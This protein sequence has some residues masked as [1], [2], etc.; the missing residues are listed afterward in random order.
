MTLRPIA[1]P[2]GWNGMERW[3][4]MEH[5]V[6]RLHSRWLANLGSNT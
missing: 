5:L 1:P 3:N 2:P 4:G 6:E